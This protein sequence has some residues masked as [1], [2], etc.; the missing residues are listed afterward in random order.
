MSPLLQPLP[1]N[2]EV[3][4]ALCRSGTAIT[5]A[6][7][8][9]AKPE[10][11]RC[12]HATGSARQVVIDLHQLQ[13]S[14]HRFAE[15]E[16]RQV[17]TE[18]GVKSLEQAAE[19]LRSR[20]NGPVAWSLTGDTT[21]MRSYGL[22]ARFLRAAL[23]SLPSAKRPRLVAD[24]G[25]S[26]G[27][28]ALNGFHFGDKFQYT[29]VGFVARENLATIGR[30]SL[31]VV[32][33]HATRGAAQVLGTLGDLTVCIGGGDESRYVC[34]SALSRGSVV[35]LFAPRQYSPPSFVESYASDSQLADAERRGR[36]FV[37]TNL[38]DI[39]RTINIAINAAT[40]LS[41]PKRAERLEV[42]KRYLAEV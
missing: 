9:L 31:M 2:G 10:G 38:S 26:F 7:R 23:S 24:N 13:K 35:V 27:V 4:A 20:L 6:M 41:V 34:Q 18:F 32:R 37:C 3:Y 42:M 33:R 17:I 15:A 21:T 5:P 16:I 11:L 30:R 12:T 28:P 36:L 19:Q 40:R 39:P 14:R 22:E 25:S 8:L 1:S 29:T